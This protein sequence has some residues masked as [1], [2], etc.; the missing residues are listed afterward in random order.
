MHSPVNYITK[1][2]SVSGVP[3]IMPD[4]LVTNNQHQS[5]WAR[6]LCY[7]RLLLKAQFPG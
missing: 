5:V 1:H 2:V 3:L 4:D 7:E 6:N